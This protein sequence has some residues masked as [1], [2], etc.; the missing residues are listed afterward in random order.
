ML[1][2]GP[3]ESRPHSLITHASYKT[4]LNVLITIKTCYIL[5]TVYNVLL[6]VYKAEFFCNRFNIQYLEKRSPDKKRMIRSNADFVF[7]NTLKFCNIQL[8]VKCL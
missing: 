1:S 3:L 4:V 2:V 7:I 6:Q 5:E 8:S